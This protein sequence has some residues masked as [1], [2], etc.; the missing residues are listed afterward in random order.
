MM[1]TRSIAAFHEEAKA[2]FEA[3]AK[4]RSCTLPIHLRSVHSQQRQII[5]AGKLPW[6]THDFEVIELLGKGGGGSVFKAVDQE[7]GH[8]VALKKISLTH[9]YEPIPD[10]LNYFHYIRPEIETHQQLEHPAIVQCYGHFFCSSS[11]AF[12]RAIMEAERSTE[13]KAASTT[14]DPENNG[15]STTAEPASAAEN[16][17]KSTTSVSESSLESLS[18]CSSYSSTSTLVPSCNE[19]DGACVVLILELCHGGSLQDAIDSRPSGRFAERVAAQHAAVLADGLSYLH[20]SKQVVHNDFKAP[21]ILLSKD[22]QP[23]I[24]DFGS[25]DMNPD[26][27]SSLKGATPG[28]VAPEFME[29]QR[30]RDLSIPV[31]CDERMDVWCLGVVAYF[32]LVGKLPFSSEI[33]DVLSAFYNFEND[34]DLIDMKLKEKGHLDLDSVDYWEHLNFEDLM[35]P[36]PA[37]NMPDFLSEEAK[38][39]IKSLLRVKP[40]ERMSLESAMSHPWILKHAGK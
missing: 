36:L 22:G 16:E 29:F 33:N 27:K 40:S 9:P 30:I 5:A 19:G 28:Y 31:S 23:K 35:L 15:N 25:S 12:D 2:K 17:A 3:K 6:T 26:L 10:D 38:H 13:K 21:N 7:T 37:L 8:P 18:A 4:T 39:F 11:R 20:Q 14:T 1:T 34:F 32:M 24:A